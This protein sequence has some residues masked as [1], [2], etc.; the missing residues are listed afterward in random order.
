MSTDNKTQG[1]NS[2]ADIIRTSKFSGNP[3]V[4]C[5][6]LG[7]PVCVCPK[8]ASE[9]EA[10]KKFEETIRMDTIHSLPSLKPDFLML[11]EAKKAKLSKTAEAIKTYYCIDSKD[12]AQS[13]Q[14]NFD[15]RNTA[16]TDFT[17][18]QENSTQTDGADDEIDVYSVSV[19]P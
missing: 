10:E 11:S 19:C 16:E 14:A 1:S 7:L 13:A 4:K 9:S 8:G 15:E 18:R 2:Y 3:C 6:A 12:N 5:D 17:V